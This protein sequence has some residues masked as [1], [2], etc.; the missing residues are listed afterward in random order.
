MSLQKHFSVRPASLQDAEGILQCLEEAFAP[1]RNTYT[2]SAFADT[3]LTLETLRNRFAR[4]R[5]LVAIDGSGRVLGTVAYKTENGEGH[6]RGMAVLPEC[7]GSGIAKGLLDQVQSD[8][9]E[10]NCRAITLNTTRPLR[11]AI[12]F[13]ERNGF[14]ATGQIGSF[15]GMELL[16]YRKGI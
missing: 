14:H 11:R 16:A 15:F 10:L 12:R 5:V 9:R 3:V 1:F 8:V 13:Y 4:M 7:Q 2:P 6:I